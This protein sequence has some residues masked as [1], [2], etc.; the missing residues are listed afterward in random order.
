MIQKVQIKS[1]SRVL[2]LALRHVREIPHENKLM[3]RFLAWPLATD[4]KLENCR[5]VCTTA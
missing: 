1:R 2:G 3:F 4:D 5:Y